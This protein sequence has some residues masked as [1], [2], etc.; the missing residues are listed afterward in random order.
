MHLPSA[1]VNQ[2]HL[3]ERVSPR[4][5]RLGVYVSVASRYVNISVS[6]ELILN[7]FTLRRSSIA[8]KKPAFA[9]F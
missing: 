9:Q 8:S 4:T 3:K 7:Y 6:Y 2:L 1:Y 5:S